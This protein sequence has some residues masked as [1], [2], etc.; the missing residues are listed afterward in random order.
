ML[1]RA[2]WRVLDH[3]P[4]TPHL[5]Q[6]YGCLNKIKYQSSTTIWKSAKFAICWC[7]FWTCN[8]SAFENSI[9]RTPPG[10]EYSSCARAVWHPI[11][12]SLCM[13][14]NVFLASHRWISSLIYDIFRVNLV[15]TVVYNSRRREEYAAAIEPHY[16]EEEHLCVRLHKIV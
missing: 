5:T 4:H 10:S 15:Q 6:L 16:L 13:C 14:W 9:S 3:D 2:H 12:S 8:Y 11:S 7:T 1:L